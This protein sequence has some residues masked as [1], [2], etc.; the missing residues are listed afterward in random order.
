MEF[1]LEYKPIMGQRQERS[2]TRGPAELTDADRAHMRSGGRVAFT[3]NA[4]GSTTKTYVRGP[5]SSAQRSASSAR[6]SSATKQSRP[7]R[8][9][10]QAE[11]QAIHDRWLSP[12]AQLVADVQ[13]TTAAVDRL[14]ELNEQRRRGRQ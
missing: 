11:L 2:A 8:P 13:R 9:A 1:K 7:A 14:L 12:E 4:D 6:S 5:A 10:S 3:K